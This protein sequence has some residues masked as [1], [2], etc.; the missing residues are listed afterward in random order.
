ME[1][2]LIGLVAFFIARL[3]MTQMLL[4]HRK[5]TLFSEGLWENVI[6]AYYVSNR[7]MSG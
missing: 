7:L 4:E 2:L 3:E 6:H 1:M 5:E